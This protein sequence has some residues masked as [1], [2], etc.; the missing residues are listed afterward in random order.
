MYGQDDHRGPDYEPAPQ[1]LPADAPH[2]YN[3]TNHYGYDD[4]HAAWASPARKRLFVLLGLPVIVVSALMATV[5]AFFVYYTVLFP[6]PLSMRKAAAGAHVRIVGSNGAV[7]AERGASGGYV[8]VELLP[9]HVTNAV[10]AIED[11]RFYQHAGFDVF[12]LL[13]ASVANIRAGRVVQGGS[14]LTQQLAKNM[15]LSPERTIARKAEEFVL[16]LWL[17]LRLT[18]RDIL[19]LYLNRVYFGAG[20]HGIDAA[21]RRYFNKPAPAL[22][23][24][25]A[26]VLAGLLKAPSKYSPRA[27]PDLAR[28]RGLLVLSAMR[29]AGLLTRSEDLAARAA[30]VKFATQ[31]SSPKHA[32]AGYA[33][34]YVLDRAADYGGSDFK[35][36]IVET[37]LDGDLQRSA[38]Q[39]L[40]RELTFA[41]ATADAGQGAVVIVG[42]EGGIRAMVGGRSYARSQYNRAVRARRQPGSAF[43][44]FLFLAAVENGMTPDSIVEASKIKLGEWSPRN[45]NGRYAGAVTLTDALANSTNTVAVRLILD[46]GAEKIAGTAERLGM[47]SVL[48]TDTSLALGTSEVSLLELVGAYGAFANGGYVHEPYAIRRILTGD[49]RVLYTRFK[50]SSAPTIDAQ[51]VGHMNKMLKSAVAK[52]T[53]TGARLKGHEVAGK[54]GTS[55][56][57]RDAWFVGYT[58]HYTAGIWVGND[59]G[60]P[61]KNVS[62]GGLPAKIWQSIMQSAHSG[63][64]SR[65]LA[66]AKISKVAKRKRSSAKLRSASK[67]SGTAIRLDNRAALEMTGTGQ[68]IVDPASGSILVTPP[69]SR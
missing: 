35:Q 18:K 68:T 27:R 12:G 5:G 17:E 50:A 11:R 43:K 40:K 26:A 13:R 61:M 56:D 2:Y 62:G 6:D 48:R 28:Q 25:E 31:L 49:G 21:A 4:S 51:T 32:D 53:A 41:G 24:S 14:T 8:P 20:A 37:T 15:F 69:G 3:S 33:I 66:K 65:P 44:P 9:V 10:L 55:Q 59:D 63:L 39:I 34:D 30:E 54:T 45:A 38:S 29:S 23:I 16:A 36:I 64:A 46:L 42:P 19:E 58:G 47:K 22:S 57:F 52:G 67:T 60:T 1:R 7:I